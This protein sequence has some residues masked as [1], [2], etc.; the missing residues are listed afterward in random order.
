MG[1]RSVQKGLSRIADSTAHSQLCNEG[2]SFHICEVG[3]YN[4]DSRCILGWHLGFVWGMGT[5]AQCLNQEL[6][7]HVTII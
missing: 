6:A 2:L 1:S 4:S 5:P 7:N 3:R